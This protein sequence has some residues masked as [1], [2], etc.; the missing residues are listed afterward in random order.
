M[1]N[2]TPPKTNIDTQDDGPWKMYLRLQTWLFG[3][4]CVRFLV[5][6]SLGGGFKDF[7]FSAL[8]GEDVHF[9]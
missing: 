1:V 4:I 5:N 2:G 6:G 7:L 3:G 9:D 8:L